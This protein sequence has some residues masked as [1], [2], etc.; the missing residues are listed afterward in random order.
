MSVYGKTGSK[1][2]KIS[3]LESRSSWEG[4]TTRVSGIRRLA[5]TVTFSSR[6]T[7]RV[8]A[9]LASSSRASSR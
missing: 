6:L 7:I 3:S 5:S 1:G 4:S 9:V 8:P 2:P